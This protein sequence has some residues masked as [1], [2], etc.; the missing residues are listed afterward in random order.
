MAGVHCLHKAKD[1]GP[2]DLADHQAI[3]PEP[4][5]GAHQ[6]VQV[7]CRGP[8]WRS[9]TGLEPHHMLRTDGQ[10][11]GV[12]QNDDAFVV[13]QSGI[14]PDDVAPLTTTLQR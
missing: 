9:R 5:R 4:K 3:R 2:T 13:R 8:I 7:D 1:L 10:L 11:G 6:V 14:L 12:F